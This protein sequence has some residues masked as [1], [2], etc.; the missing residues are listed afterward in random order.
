ME[1]T[2]VLTEATL[3]HPLFVDPRFQRL[4]FGCSLLAMAAV[5]GL[6][7]FSPRA[8]GVPVLYLL[9]FW[10]SLWWAAAAQT[11]AIAAVASLLTL[12]GYHAPDASEWLL[13]GVGR[14]ITLIVLW[15]L[16]CYGLA[17]RRAVGDLQRREREL[18]DFYENAPAGHLLVRSDGIIL[19]ANREAYAMLGLTPDDYLSC[20]I[21]EFQTDHAEGDRML[22]L[23]KAG[24]PFRN[25]AGQ[26]RHRDGSIREVL[27]SSSTQR[28]EAPAQMSWFIRDITDRQRAD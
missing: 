10:A 8:I 25:H 27:I 2:M 24:H 19:R 16:T 23:L 14:V 22:A 26:F 13:D 20:N 12:I 6:D 15:F 7:W 4:G 18:G 11:V 1:D 5:F 9:I 28:R 3:G 17:Y 21:S